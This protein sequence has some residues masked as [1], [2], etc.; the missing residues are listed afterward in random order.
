MSCADGITT[1]QV[2]PDPLPLD[3]E[4][5]TVIDVVIPYGLE[6][7]VPLVTGWNFIG[8]SGSDTDLATAVAGH[9]GDV[10]AIYGY[11]AST[12]TWLRYVPGAPSM[13]NTLTKLTAGQAYWVDVKSPFTLTVMK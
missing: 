1:Q 10:I 3:G 11:D 9:E 5:N 7:D 12:A 2:V 13:V 8:A 4:G 6:K